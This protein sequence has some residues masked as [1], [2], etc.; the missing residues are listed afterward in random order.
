MAKTLIAFYS[1][2]GQ[3]YVDGSIRNLSKGNNEVIV[4]KI[5]ALLPEADVFRLETVKEYAVDYYEC[6]QEAKEELNA[7]ARPA[8]KADIDISKYDTIYLGWPCWW[9]TYPMCVA[10]FLEAHDWSGKT[11]IPFT[12]HE[13][14]GFGSGLRDLKAAI[15]QATVKKGLSIQGSK[16]KTAG[17][18]IEEFVKGQK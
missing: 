17:K 3:N 14:S 10:T 4:E 6:T 8:L 1:R 12:T 15:P 2:R 16:V 18:Q 7:K 5:K 9:G 11:V 13:G